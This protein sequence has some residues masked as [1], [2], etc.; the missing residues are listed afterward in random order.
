MAAGR[1]RHDDTIGRYRFGDL[2]L[3]VGQLRVCRG[4]KPLALPR[5]SFELL[6][7]L[8]EAAPNVVSHEEIARSVWGTG[9]V[10]TPENLT[11]RLLMVRQS[12]GD[13]AGDPR[14]IESV[15]GQ[16]YR[17]IPGVVP[18]TDRDAKARDPRSIPVAPYRHEWSG[19]AFS[20]G[21]I[22]M[23]ALISSIGLG[24]FLANNEMSAVAAD[25]RDFGMPV[26]MPLPGSIA[27]L[28]FE[29]LNEEPEPTYFA[30]AL[31]AELV[32]ALG[33]RSGLRVIARASVLEYVGNGGRLARI[34]NELGVD[35][36]VNGTIRYDAGR[37]H[38]IAELVELDTGLRLWG[39]N[40][41][42]VTDELFSVRTRM[43]ESI[44]ETL[45]TPLI[46][47]RGPPEDNGAKA[48]AYAIF[49][50]AMD[51]FDQDNVGTRASAQTLL[52]QA[53]AIDP[54]LAY[55]YAGKSVIH[56]F[57][58]INSGDAGAARALTPSQ[59]EAL[60]REY[61]DQALAL[62]AQTDLAYYAAGLL[63]M[64]SWNFAAAHE[65]LTA[66]V[67]ASPQHGT[68]LA[69]LGWL[70]VCG[71]GSRAG[72]RYSERAATVDPRNPY[73]LERLSA[74]LDCVGELPAALAATERALELDPGGFGNQ[75]ARAVLL[76]RIE[77]EAR[78]LEAFRRLEP[79]LTERR[80]L[81]LP[82]I[83]LAYSQ[84]GQPEA[85]ER[86]VRRFAEL[87]GSRRTGP[88]NWYMAYL[89]IDDYD[90]AFASLE[91]AVTER[92]LG[93]GFYT[94]M[95]FFNNRG[96]AAPFDEPRFLALRD[97]LRASARS[98][99]PEP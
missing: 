82:G 58:A 62:D 51:I 56:V 93:P 54:G 71:L 80:V 6:R 52:D 30:E 38:L 65:N 3:D 48:E 96:E 61:I 73:V 86:A 20:I 95:T 31:H 67:A 41:T 90:R 57:S 55:A 34:G 42:L 17:L 78:G 14:Y 79:L 27:V 77:G 84:L 69:Q 4:G 88:A 36:A 22:A 37:M 40:Y 59:H 19:G 43:I 29:K 24:R 87:A 64:F 5:L 89:A 35:F 66:A 92:R 49:L 13:E 50:R 72:I 97:R 16:G 81:T 53:I 46:E 85:A 21:L 39:D 7:V 1:A 83:A 28:P 18:L 70:E 32:D 9:R 2:V 26:T 76:G 68:F 12:I 91:Q 60:A 63:E 98:G 75:L 44:S 33:R 10:V 15:R 94:L 99:W 45:A 25:S 11:Q 8:V 23:L 47:S 74:A